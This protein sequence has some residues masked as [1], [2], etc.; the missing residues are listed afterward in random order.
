MTFYSFQNN[1]ITDVLGTSGAPV[2]SEDGYCLGH[3]QSRMRPSEKA[4]DEMNDSSTQR[5]IQYLCPAEYV[6]RLSSG[7][8]PHLYRRAAYSGPL[9]RLRSLTTLLLGKRELNILILCQS[10]LSPADKNLLN[11]IGTE[12]EANLQNY[13]CKVAVQEKLPDVI[14]DIV[15]IPAMKSQQQF[16]EGWIRRHAD[17]PKY[18]FAVIMQVDI[19]GSGP[20]LIY[21]N[22]HQPFDISPSSLLR[23]ASTQTDENTFIQQM[24]EVAFRLQWYIVNGLSL[25]R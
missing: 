9:H 6:V 7:V 23:H 3:V 16:I 25:A 12:L 18:R 5:G 24:M 15:L 17:E 13:D 2:L 22:Q 21:P 20:G 4:E 19:D 8:L 11:N 1:P 10:S 14:A